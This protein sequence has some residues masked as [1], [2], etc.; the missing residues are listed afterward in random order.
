LTPLA[1]SEDSG[2]PNE[3]GDSSNAREAIRDLERRLAQVSTKTDA[4]IAA[5]I[6][7]GSDLLRARL[8]RDGR[9]VASPELEAA[10]GCT[11][12]DLEQACTR[13]ELFSWE[14]AGQIWYAGTFMTLVRSD[15]AAV[16]V[17]LRRLDPA[18][19]FFF[20]HR[21]HGSLRGHT[22][23]QAL[24]NGELEAVRQ[25]ADSFVREQFRA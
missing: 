18:S 13:G 20:W 10:W 7:R 1:V 2:T 9:L 5:E 8:I 22:L 14:I 24:R 16:S 25:V 21:K 17:L 11:A 23:H 15:V 3:G 12:H 4:E 6:A 19:Q